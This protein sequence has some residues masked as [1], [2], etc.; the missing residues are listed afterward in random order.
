MNVFGI[1]FVSQQAKG[2][3]PAKLKPENNVRLS[4]Q[5]PVKAAPPKV[6]PPVKPAT[7]PR[8]TTAAPARAT[9]TAPRNRGRP[10]AAP[11]A[12][13]AA[14][15]A[16]SP[17]ATATAAT[18]APKPSSVALPD[19]TQYMIQTREA[20]GK[21]IT[22]LVPLGPGQVVEQGSNAVNVINMTSEPI[23]GAQPVID[24]TAEDGQATATAQSLDVAADK[25]SAIPDTPESPVETTAAP[26]ES[27]FVDME[28]WLIDW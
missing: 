25:Q 1:I 5:P 14:A 24:L 3:D 7:Q 10:R 19:G 17:A 21:T 12:A 20:D 2:I 27:D 18:A 6:A 28:S 23:S 8:A 13:K 4:T 26:E 16:Q 9:T 22:F 11:L 15:P